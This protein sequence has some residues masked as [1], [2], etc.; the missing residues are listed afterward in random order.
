M[1]PRS[2]HDGQ[3]D[4]YF[5][6][7]APNEIPQE[8][9]ATFDAKMVESFADIAKDPNRIHLDEAV[10]KARGL[11]GRL[12]HGMLIAAQME[13]F[14]LEKAE[15]ALDRNLKLHSIRW[16]FRDMTLVGETLN[17]G[18]V[19]KVLTSERAELH[20]SAQTPDASTRVTAVLE[21]KT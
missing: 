11:P 2:L 1:R 10:A 14:A 4:I 5:S 7:N 21:F 16:R 12:V 9:L 17:C 20:L 19:W 3:H 6:M 15:R 8:K 13:R 18:G